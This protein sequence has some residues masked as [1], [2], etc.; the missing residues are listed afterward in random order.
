MNRKK[1]SLNKAKKEVLIT[2]LSIQASRLDQFMRRIY[3]DTI[4]QIKVADDRILLT[5]S[6]VNICK[7]SLEPIRAINPEAADILNQLLL[8]RKEYATLI[9]CVSEFNHQCDG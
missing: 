2:A 3:D 6:Q 9:K 5:V 4:A 1:L 7:V 8:T